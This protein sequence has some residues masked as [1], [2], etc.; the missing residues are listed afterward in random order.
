MCL[1]I[2]TG[3]ENKGDAN[4]SPVFLIIDGKDKD[5]LYSK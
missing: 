3:Q 2:I 5:H 4:L 1:I